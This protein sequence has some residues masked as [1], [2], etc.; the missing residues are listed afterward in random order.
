MDRTDILKAKAVLA[1]EGQWLAL[2]D[3][4]NPAGLRNQ[5]SVVPEQ[6]TRGKPSDQ[7]LP[8]KKVELTPLTPAAEKIGEGKDNLRARS[9]AFNR[10]RRTTR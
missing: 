5:Q 3:L 1:K 8:E 9:N 7:I 2:A 6:N 10:R 4:A